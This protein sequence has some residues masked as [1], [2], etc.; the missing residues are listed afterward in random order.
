M[1]VLKNAPSRSLTFVHSSHV[2]GRGNLK[3]DC[4]LEFMLASHFPYIVNCDLGFLYNGGTLDI[5]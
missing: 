1:H 4:A 3:R 5:L 2:K